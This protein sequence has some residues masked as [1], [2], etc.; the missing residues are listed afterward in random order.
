MR[1]RIKISITNYMQ[2]KS[3]VNLEEARKDFCDSFVLNSGIN[4]ETPLTSRLFTEYGTRI[5]SLSLQKAKWKDSQLK[6]LLFERL[7]NL[8]QLSIDCTVPKPNAKG[9]FL[10]I[11]DGSGARRILPKLKYLSVN[12]TAWDTVGN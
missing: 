11:E 5:K 7:P 12:A 4:I 2:V 3:Y 6:T 1:G 8:E 10:A 9:Q